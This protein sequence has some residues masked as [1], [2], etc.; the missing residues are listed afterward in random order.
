MGQ[1]A[2]APRLESPRLFQKPEPMAL[3][4]GDARSP[5]QSRVVSL[6]ETALRETFSL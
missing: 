3:A 6:G 4:T 1:W 2:L 5:R